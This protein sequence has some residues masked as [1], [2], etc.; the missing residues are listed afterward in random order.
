M[1]KGEYLICGGCFCCNEYLDLNP[2]ACGAGEIEYCLLAASLFRGRVRRRGGLSRRR[3]AR[4]R[5]SRRRAARDAAEHVA[6]TPRARVDAAAAGCCAGDYV[7]L[8]SQHVPLSAASHA[9]F[10]QSPDIFTT[11]VLSHVK[12]QLQQHQKQQ[13]IKQQPSPAAP[14][15]C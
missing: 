12:M 7:C 9:A 8:G 14:S 10:G 4:H 13:N 15:Q 11:C 3:R 6:A 2:P 1:D 5:T